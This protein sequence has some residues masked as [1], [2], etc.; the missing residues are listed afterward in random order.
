MAPTPVAV[1]PL[2]KFAR[3]SALFV[4]IAYGSRRNKTLEKQEA[5]VL[6]VKAIRDEAIAKKQAEEAASAASGESGS[7]FD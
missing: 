1:S 2:I 7:I 6:R 3:Y 5:E 4:G